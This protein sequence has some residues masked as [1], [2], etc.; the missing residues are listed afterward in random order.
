MKRLLPLLLA[1]TAC[2]STLRCPVPVKLTG[3]SG[4]V[5]AR[6][7]APQPASWS[8]HWE[9][10]SVRVGVQERY[11]ELWCD[12]VMVATLPGQVTEVGHDNPR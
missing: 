11:A 6:C 5:V 1:A 9:C 3:V 2:G 4:G 7:V 10:V 8:R 12:D